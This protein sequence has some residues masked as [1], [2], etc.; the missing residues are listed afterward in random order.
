[1]ATKPLVPVED[2]LRWK[3]IDSPDPDYVDGELVERHLGGKPH[4][5]IQFNLTA[6]FA[7]LRKRV[8]LQVFPELHLKLGPRHY[9]VAD[10]AVF[11][12]EPAE[13]IP[14]HPPLIT[15]EIIS[16]EDS[17]REVRS[18]SAD[19]FAWGVRHVWLVD[20]A[21]R[22]SSVYDGT[23]HDVPKFELPEFGVEITPEQVFA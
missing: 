10:V 20:P 1:M 4:S 22:T 15:I 5:R 3:S 8:P 23:F 17:L 18:K 13:D 2:Y 12:E 7:E 11:T 6:I 14:S 9:R 21:S 16:P 19:Y